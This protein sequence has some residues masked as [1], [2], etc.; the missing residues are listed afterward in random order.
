[1]SILSRFKDIMSSRTG[2]VIANA[3]DPK[4]SINDFLRNLLQDL[5]KVK[6]EYALV[7]EEEKRLKR[8][9]RECQANMEKLERYAAKALEAKNEEDAR[10]FLEKKAEWGA[11]LAE[12]QASYERVSEGSKQLKQMHDKLAADIGEWQSRAN[13]LKSK[14]DVSQAQ[15]KMNKQSSENASFGQLEE[16]IEKKLYE[17]EALAELRRDPLADPDD[18]KQAM[19]S[20]DIDADLEA[21]KD[22]IKDN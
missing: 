3:K 20:Q 7:M 18:S 6:A 2:D 16:E 14:W 19:Q 12:L 15:E 9:M 4:A 8:A 10:A 13:V 5:G 17:A 1:M 21:L 11:K 22:K